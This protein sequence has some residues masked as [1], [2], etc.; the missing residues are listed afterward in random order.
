MAKKTKV[1]ISD[2]KLNVFD[3]KR[4]AYLCFNGNKYQHIKKG[5][6]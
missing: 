3:L 2:I 1:K 4:T 5:N 6:D